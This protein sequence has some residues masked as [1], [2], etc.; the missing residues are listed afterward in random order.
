MSLEHLTP[1]QAQFSWQVVFQARLCIYKSR[2][3]K[4][5]K[6]TSISA[7]NL[8]YLLKP[9]ILKIDDSKTSEHYDVLAL[10]LLL[11]Y[12]TQF[13][14]QKTGVLIAP[15]LSRQL[16]L[17]G[18]LSERF[19]LEVKQ[20]FHLSIHLCYAACPSAEHIQLAPVH[21]STGQYSGH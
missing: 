11:K 2:K 20:S 10:K 14:S 21:W 3:R 5:K 6:Q 16:I 1:V 19:V 9:L 17:Q 18:C 4:K 15:W 12:S 13:H 7:N 8:Q